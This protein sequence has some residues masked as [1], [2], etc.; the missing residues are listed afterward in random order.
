MNKNLNM[1][2]F[3]EYLM[4]KVDKARESLTFEEFCNIDFAEAGVPKL[5]ITAINLLS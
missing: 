3:S 1:K 4:E 2:V 5:L